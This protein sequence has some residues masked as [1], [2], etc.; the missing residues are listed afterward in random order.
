MTA[1][2]PGVIAV[3]NTLVFGVEMP[4]ECALKELGTLR[5]LVICC[6]LSRLAFA[7]ETED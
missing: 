1:T 3:V 5:W 2:E 6:I 4:W 7:F